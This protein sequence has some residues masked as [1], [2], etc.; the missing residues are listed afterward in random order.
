MKLSDQERAELY[1]KLGLTPE[2]VRRYLPK[3]AFR[4]QQQLEQRGNFEEKYPEDAITAFLVSGAQFFDKEIVLARK[5]EL[6]LFKP[7]A[8]LRG[9]QGQIFHP[10]V[11]GARYVIGADV[12]SGRTVSSTD[13]DYNAGVCL[14]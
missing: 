2:L 8:I 11:P 1:K 12:A 13:T 7:A 6:T 5:R 3:I 10:R 9:G 4:R 14:E